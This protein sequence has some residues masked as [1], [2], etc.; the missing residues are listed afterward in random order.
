[1]T[2]QNRNSG[3]WYKATGQQDIRRNLVSMNTTSTYTGKS[4]PKFRG[5]VVSFK[6]PLTPQKS[7]P[8]IT[9]AFS[10]N[11][12][13]QGLTAPKEHMASQELLGKEQRPEVLVIP[14]S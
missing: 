14:I 3:L 9:T 7:N 11:M 2:V 13:A 12:L 10:M 1:M 8:G 5:T 6:L 4:N